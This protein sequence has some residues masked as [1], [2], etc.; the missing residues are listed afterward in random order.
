MLTQLTYLSALYCVISPSSLS[1]RTEQPCNDKEVIEMI[2][3]DKLY[4]INKRSKVKL[5]FLL[6]NLNR[7]TTKVIR[8]DVRYKNCDISTITIYDLPDEIIKQIDQ[9]AQQ[10]MHQLTSYIYAEVKSNNERRRRI[11]RIF[12]NLIF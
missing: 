7:V 8:S 5:Q 4:F 1:L 6:I 9:T 3:Q 2:T 10:L 12:K 11:K